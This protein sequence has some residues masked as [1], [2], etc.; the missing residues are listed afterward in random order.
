[1]HR[2]TASSNTE[3]RLEKIARHEKPQS[4][5]E[6]YPHAKAKAIEECDLAHIT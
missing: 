1:M 5:A 6:R 2:S 4:G 3:M